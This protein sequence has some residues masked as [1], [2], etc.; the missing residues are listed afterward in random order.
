MRRIFPILGMIGGLVCGGAVWAQENDGPVPVPIIP[1]TDFGPVGLPG[2]VFV[3]PATQQLESPATA[4]VSAA[5]RILSQARN[6]CGALSDSAYH[7][8]CLA[9]RMRAAAQSLP[10]DGEMAEA[11]A[12]L[13]QAARDLAAT[14]ARYRDPARPPIR[15]RRGGTRPIST[16]RPIAPVRKA[17]EARAKAEALAILSRTETVLLRSA[18]RSAER[19]LAYQQVAAAVGSNKVLLRS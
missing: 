16:A 3:P 19:A 18:D 1:P 10:E 7:I 9:E 12:A 14:T 4:E 2:P 6:F 17:D 5:L 11:R 15:A 13:E 8:D